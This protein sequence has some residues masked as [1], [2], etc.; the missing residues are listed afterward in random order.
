[1]MS[2]AGIVY[3]IGQI[4]T[5]CLVMIVVMLVFVIVAEILQE[6]H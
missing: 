6:V 4:L 5:D 1:M 3:L 2:D